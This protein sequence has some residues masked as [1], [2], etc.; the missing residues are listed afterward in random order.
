MRDLAS[1][2]SPNSAQLLRFFSLV[3]SPSAWL[4]HLLIF[5]PPPLNTCCFL[6]L[7]DFFS[8]LL[9]GSCLLDLK[10]FAQIVALTEA[11]LA[12]PM[13]LAPFLFPSTSYSPPIIYSMV[14][15]SWM[16]HIISLSFVYLHPSPLK[17]S[18]HEDRFLPILFIPN[19]PDSRMVPG[20]YWMLTKYFLFMNE[21]LKN[22][23]SL[24]CSY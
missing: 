8:S 7:Q 12:Y 2:T 5:Y 22:G 4:T 24:E 21:C 14:F 1:V 9:S 20:I 19:I 18:L 11:F 10:V 13:K 16:F 15:I 6:N 23:K 17:Y 3:H